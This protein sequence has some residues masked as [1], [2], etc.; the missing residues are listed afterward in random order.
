[1]RHEPAVNHAGYNPM[2]IEVQPLLFDGCPDVKEIRPAKF[3][4]HRGFFSEVY[5]KAD[6][7][8]AGIALEFVQDNHSLSAEK[9]TLRGLHFQTPP[10]AQA[11]L[12]RVT[13]GAIYDVAVDIRT[14]SPTFGKHAAAIISAAKWNQLL[15]PAGFAHGF[16]TLEPDTEV[17][18]KVDAPYSRDHDCG[19]KWD[20]PDLAIDWP[21]APSQAIVSEK[22][23]NHPPLRDLPAF[24]RY[25]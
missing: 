22:D 20:D 14:G 3:G 25:A 17:L 12:V 2:P 7:A 16:V 10:I 5:S 6:M 19:L 8:A 23:S 21:V 13:R 18:Y 15:V 9:G 1:M 11:K 24:F 4:D